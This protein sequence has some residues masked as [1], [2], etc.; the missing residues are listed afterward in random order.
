MIFD[1]DKGIR[2]IWGEDKGYIAVKNTRPSYIFIFCFLYSYTY[3]Y[4]ERLKK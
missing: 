3:L 2:F 1:S 4:K